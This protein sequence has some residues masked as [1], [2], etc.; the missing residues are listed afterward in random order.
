MQRA[1]KQRHPQKAAST[2]QSRTLRHQYRRHLS[3]SRRA[4][5]ILGRLAAKNVAP[6][7]DSF[8]C[9]SADNAAD[10]LGHLQIS[11]RI[12]RQKGRKTQFIYLSRG[13]AHLSCL[14]NAPKV[15]VQTFVRTNTSIYRGH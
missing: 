1:R 15:R 5:A 10:E 11:A 4:K 7:S 13:S 8:M 14:T 12:R 2:A 3:P 6:S 9:N